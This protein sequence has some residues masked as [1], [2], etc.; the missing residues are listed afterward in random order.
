MIYSLERHHEDDI[1]GSGMC[2]MSRRL[3]DDRRDIW[4]KH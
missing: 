3:L 1:C 2:E 4:Y